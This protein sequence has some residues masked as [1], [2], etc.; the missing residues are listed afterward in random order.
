MKKILCT[1]CLGMASL[2]ASVSAATIELMPEITTIT[3]QGYN[4][5]GRLANNNITAADV[6]AWLGAAGR[7]DGWYTTTGNGDMRWGQA[8]VNAADQTIS[9]PNMP[10]TAGVCAGLKMTI[11]N[12]Q[13]YSGLTFSFSLTPPGTG[14]T[15]TYSVWYETT[16]GD[17]VELCRGSRG[18]DASEWNVSYNL[19][20]EQLAAMKAN[21]NGKVY[22][23]IGSSGG[24]NGNN[25]TVHDVSL[26]GTLAVTEPKS[27]Y[28]SNL[29]LSTQ[30]LSRHWN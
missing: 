3:G 29:R 6:K 24:N 9:L 11:E 14:P 1:I 4:S 7:A 2:A 25:G 13:A 8:S 20:D 22:A 15:Y 28:L 16:D 23:V 30:I 17:L 10:G 27:T 18:N 5:A 12:I 21:G 26:E 19:T